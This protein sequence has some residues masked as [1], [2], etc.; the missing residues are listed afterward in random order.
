MEKRREKAPPTAASDAGLALRAA[1]F[2][3]LALPRDGHTRLLLAPDG[4][5]ARLPFEVLPTDDGRRLIDDYH[6]SYLSCGRDVLRF[7]A[8]ST[9][10]PAPPMIL[11][12]P[13]FDLERV[14]DPRAR[15][16]PEP[17]S[18]PG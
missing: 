6:I 10:E 3:R 15:P 4:D 13:D 16:S 1:L 12:D 5:L 17:V 18:G 7:G 9:G 14:G 8:A 2:D 11:A